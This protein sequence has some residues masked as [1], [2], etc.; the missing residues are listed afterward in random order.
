M[1]IFDVIKYPLSN[2]IVRLD[3]YEAL[4]QALKDRFMNDDLK[5]F[6]KSNNY[7]IL[8]RMLLEHENDDT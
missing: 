5:L 3:E 7:G 2:P 6:P 1:T 8:T 4:P